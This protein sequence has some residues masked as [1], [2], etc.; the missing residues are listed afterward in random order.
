MGFTPSKAEQ[1]LQGMELQ[2]KETHTGNLF[3]KDLQ[4]KSVC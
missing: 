4:L 1:P 2:E 3:R